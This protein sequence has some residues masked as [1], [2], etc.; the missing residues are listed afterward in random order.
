MVGT[1]YRWVRREE[2]SSMKRTL[3]KGTLLVV[4]VLVGVMTVMAGQMPI[5]SQGGEQEQSTGPSSMMGRGMMC[6]M[7][8]SQMDPM[9]MMAMMGGGHTDPKDMGRVLELRGELLRAMGDVMI[10]YSQAMRRE[11]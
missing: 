7:M 3:M 1:A 8:G 10:K 4:L 2:G 5:G 11:P 9:G 6:P